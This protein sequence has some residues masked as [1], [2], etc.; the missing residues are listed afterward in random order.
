MADSTPGLTSF[1]VIWLLMLLAMTG[2][3]L[4][5]WMPGDV[6]RQPGEAAKQIRDK[7]VRRG[8]RVS[9]GC[10]VK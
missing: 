4:L 9:R 3:F 2:M 7:L 1:V 6:V 8:F 5:L 10:A